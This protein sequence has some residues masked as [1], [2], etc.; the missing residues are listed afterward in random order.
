MTGAAQFVGRFHPLL[1]HFPIAFLV[2]AAALELLAAGRRPERAA[3]AAAAVPPLLALA[4]FTAA[5]AAA[6]GYLLGRSSGYAGQTFERHL[7]LGIVVA[8]TATVTAL[9]AWQ[10]RR[11][12]GSGTTIVRACLAVTLAALVAAGHLGATLTHG[13]GYLTEAAPPAIRGLVAR[14]FG[15]SAA[16]PASGPAGQAPVYTA[17]V[18]PILQ[19]HC[20][21]CHSGERPQGALRL[22]TPDAILKGG[23][24]GPVIAP[25]RAVSSEIVRRVWLPP[26]HADAMPPRGQRPLAAADAGVL[27]W[28][29]DSG[30]SFE[31]TLADVEVPPEI[32]PV[33]ESRLGPIARGGPSLPAVTLA[34]PDAARV[35]ALRAP[36]LDIR[37]IADGSPFVQVRLTGRAPVTDDARIASLAPLAPHVLWLTLADSGIT[38]TAFTT[39]AG[40]KNLTRLDVS[41]TATGDAGIH[42]AGALP[43]LESLNLYGTRIT[44][45]G[46]APLG[47]LPRLRRVYLWQTAVTPAGIEKLK[48]DNPKLEVVTTDENP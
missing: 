22:D 2:L 18:Q 48:T 43:Y 34:A 24:H 39:I 1:V 30:A 41:R 4:A 7:Q 21:A 20:V 14:L 15:G 31:Q 26:G 25:G 27:R 42:A 33:L 12:G 17:V 28:W 45:A 23:D 36:G 47:A 16:A 11:L 46:L 40:M 5:V 10:R 35:E 44:D 8:V 29:V 13:E 19:Q 3:R 6:A 38:D 9:A 37:S 32:L